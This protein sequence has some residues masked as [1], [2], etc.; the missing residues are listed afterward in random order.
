MSFDDIPE[1][2]ELS[3]SCPKCHQGSV[4]QNIIT[5]KWGCFSCDFSAGQD[6]SDNQ[7]ETIEG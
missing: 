6:E 7:D 3:F 5:G 2:R 1:D 4:T